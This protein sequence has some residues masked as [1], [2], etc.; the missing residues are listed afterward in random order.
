MTDRRSW[1]RF[2]LRGKVSLCVGA[3]KNPTS[4]LLP[5]NIHDT[6]P[7]ACARPSS[8]G[9]SSSPSFR[10]PRRRSSPSLPILWLVWSA[11][12]LTARDFKE[13]CSLLL[14]RDER[15]GL[16][17]RTACPHAFAPV[18]FPTPVRSFLT[19]SSLSAVQRLC[20]PRTLQL[21]VGS[22]SSTRTEAFSAIVCS[23]LMPCLRPPLMA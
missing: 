7:S 13:V 4:F 19:G 11:L 8:P 22:A 10:R 1:R 2:C 12:S 15:S 16:E 23:C 17:V 6:S 18:I 3:S 20:P 21:V 9:H 14:R 5:C